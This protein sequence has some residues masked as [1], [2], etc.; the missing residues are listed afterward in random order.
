MR[1]LKMVYKISIGGNN[2]NRIN[3]KKRTQDINLKA[4]EP[5][6]TDVSMQEKKE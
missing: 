6:G 4:Q 5:V 3:T 1:V 2:Y